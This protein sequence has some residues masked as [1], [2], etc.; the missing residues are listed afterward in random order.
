MSIYELGL[1]INLVIMAGLIIAIFHTE[2]V[3]IYNGIKYPVRY[4]DNGRIEC[5]L[6]GN[7]KRHI[8]Y[9]GVYNVFG[10][11]CEVQ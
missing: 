7:V 6:F 10:V 3:I 11:L 8:K 5:K 2:N 4:L 9:N 1:F